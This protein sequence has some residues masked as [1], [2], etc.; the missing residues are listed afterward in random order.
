MV[1]ALLADVNNHGQRQ[2]KLSPCEHQN[3]ETYGQRVQWLIDN[4]ASG[5]ARE[6]GRRAGLKNEGNISVFMQRS[7]L[8]P[9]AKLDPESIDLFVQN[10]GVRREWLMTGLGP[11]LREG[12]ELEPSPLGFSPDATTTRTGPGRWQR[13]AERYWQFSA[14]ATV[15]LARGIPPAALDAAS[16]YL[17]AQKGDGPTEADASEAIKR[18]ARQIAAEEPAGHE[19]S[20]DEFEVPKTMAKKG[21]R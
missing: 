19:A 2:L 6:L 3:V 9:S 13:Y 1:S 20:D 7:R 14:Q 21:K 11:P 12:E 10:L 8:K 17:G 18:Y 16:D 5:N 4:V 15:A